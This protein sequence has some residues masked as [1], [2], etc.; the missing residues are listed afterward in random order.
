MPRKRRILVPN[1]PHHIV[2]RG[3]NRK[4]V[5]IAD[6]DYRYYLDNLREFKDAFGIRLYAWRL[7]TNHIHLVLEPG[8]DTRTVSELMKRLAGRQSAYVNKLEKRTGSLW[9]GRFKVSAIQKSEYLLACV[10][11]VEMNPVR[12]GIVAGPRQYKWSGY[13]ERI[14]AVEQGLL[15]LDECYMGLASSEDERIRRYKK[16]VRNGASDRELALL[17]GSLR[18]NQLTGDQR[19]IDEIETRI[20]IRVEARSRGRPRKGK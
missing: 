17:R 20:G 2:Q 4:A 16:Y 7:M 15:D 10:R 11:Y 5:F 18:R 9:E 8:D 1:C 12:A 19:F 6:G 14:K 13:R 3:H